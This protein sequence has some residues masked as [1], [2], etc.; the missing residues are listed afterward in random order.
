MTQTSTCAGPLF[1]MGLQPLKSGSQD[2]MNAADGATIG[3]GI[4]INQPDEGSARCKGSG[5]L[6]QPKDFSC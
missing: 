4:R 1:V 3:R 2:A 5:A 6:D